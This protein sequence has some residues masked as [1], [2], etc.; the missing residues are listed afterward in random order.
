LPQMFDSTMI[1]GNVRLRTAS[2]LILCAE[3][4]R[5]INLNKAHTSIVLL[6][7]KNLASTMLLHL[8][9]CTNLLI[10]DLTSNLFIPS[11]VP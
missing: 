3:M 8:E 9:Q 10:L 11:Y 4:L 1:Q 2:Q 7:A 5:H 6:F